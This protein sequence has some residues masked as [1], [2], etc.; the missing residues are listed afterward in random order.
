MA[1]R[2][3]HGR[4]QGRVLGLMAAAGSLGRFLGPALAVLPL[5]SNFSQLTR[6][7]SGPVL[8]TVS[9]G[10]RTAFSA[11]AGLVLVATIFTMFLRVPKDKVEAVEPVPVV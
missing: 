2:H 11:S 3:V 4:V 10:Y 7:L 8:E 1:S 9:A 5:P 6:P